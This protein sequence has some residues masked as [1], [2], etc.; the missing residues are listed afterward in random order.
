[1]TT[2]TR[3]CLRCRTQTHPS[4]IE[5]TTGEAKPLAITLRAV[6]VLECEKG[7]KQFVDAGFARRVLD[8]LVEQQPKLPAARERGMLLFKRY[9]CSGCGAE[10]KDAPQAPR[11]FPIEVALPDLAP[12]SADL[13][14][15]VYECAACSV[16][17][18][19]SA[20]DVSGQLPAALAHA[21]QLAEIPHG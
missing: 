20:D 11:S 6:P 16:A 14:L 1:M 7:H 5:Q 9:Y 2:K 17:Q 12:F 15:P 8:R 3:A 18:L 4:R 13:S 21:F 10:L 19:R